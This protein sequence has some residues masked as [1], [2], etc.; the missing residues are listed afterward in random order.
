MR[1]AMQAKAGP[2]IG[3]GQEEAKTEANKALRL[4]RNAP[5]INLT[6]RF[7]GS[8]GD[9]IGQQVTQSGMRLRLAVL[10]ARQSEGEQVVSSPSSDGS[11]SYSRSG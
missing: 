9:G 7:V 4:P 10:C 1:R 6:I 11:G 8:R 5:E 2:K 3:S